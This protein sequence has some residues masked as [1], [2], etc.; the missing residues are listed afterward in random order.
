MVVTTLFTIY[1]MESVPTLIES[2]STSRSQ[3]LKLPSLSDIISNPKLYYR[4]LYARRVAIIVYSNKYRLIGRCD[5]YIQ[6]HI[7]RSISELLYLML[8]VNMNYVAALSRSDHLMY[9]S[10]NRFWINK[11]PLS[12]I[13]IYKLYNGY[14]K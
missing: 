8:M 12:D 10:K 13:L 7:E 1:I 3:N 4:Y 14:S 6:W 2:V 11:N 5:S 9:K